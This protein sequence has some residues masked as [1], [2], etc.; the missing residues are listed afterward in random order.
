MPT[1]DYV[2]DACGHAFELFQSI[3]SD[4]EKTCPECRRRKLRRLIG[5]GAAILVGGRSSAPESESTTRSSDASSESSTDSGES[6]TTVESSGD[7][8]GDSKSEGTKT[9]KPAKEKKISGSTSTPTHEAREG[10]G[11][12]N[13]VDAVRRQ[14]KASSGDSKPAA[15]AKS[16]KS[17]KKAAKKSTGKTNGR[18]PRK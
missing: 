10:R 11:V 7:A 16:G 1:Y 8:S 12:G 5:T 13:L 3:T 4:P 9:E 2:C 14:R 18:K 6:S 17:T 15:K